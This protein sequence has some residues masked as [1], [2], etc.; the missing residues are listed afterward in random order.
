MRKASLLGNI[1]AVSVPGHVFTQFICGNEL[2]A[3][4]LSVLN[5]YLAGQKD[6]GTYPLWGNDEIK[7]VAA[8]EIHLSPEW[9]TYAGE[10]IKSR[11]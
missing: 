8:S 10:L 11:T 6:K 1:E 5:I 2:P 4:V 3:S 9:K 7:N